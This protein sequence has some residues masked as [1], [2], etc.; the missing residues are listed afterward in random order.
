MFVRMKFK[1]QNGLDLNIYGALDRPIVWVSFDTI[2][3]TGEASYYEELVLS[4]LFRTVRYDGF[5][6]NT[7]KPQDIFELNYSAK[8]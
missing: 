6:C 1:N 2:W 3:D 8:F 4:A 7:L 5:Y